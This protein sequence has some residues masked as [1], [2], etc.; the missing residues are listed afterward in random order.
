[1]IEGVN[2]IVEKVWGREIWIANTPDYCSKILEINKGF[3]CSMHHHKIKDE[4]F[5]LIGGLI[6]MEHNKE[7]MILTPEYCIRIK[8]NE[9]HRFSGI[10]YSRMLETSTHHEESDSYRG[11]ESGPFDIK[12]INKV[13]D[14]LSGGKK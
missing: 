12:R 1:M 8:P 11:E 14:I 3:R 6:F 4:T 13:F 9:W 10:E 2:K 7:E 5:Y